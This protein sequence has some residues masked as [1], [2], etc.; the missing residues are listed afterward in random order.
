[1]FLFVC[2]FF[3]SGEIFWA[4]QVIDINLSVFCGP[5]FC[6]FAKVTCTIYLF[7]SHPKEVVF[8]TVNEN[9]YGGYR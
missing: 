7:I 9:H 5:F 2:F 4:K 8:C 1:M 6:P 3:F